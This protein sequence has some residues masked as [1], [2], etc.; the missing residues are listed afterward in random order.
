LESR[1]E[2]EAKTWTATINMWLGVND[3]LVIVEAPRGR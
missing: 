3:T 2:G 1:C